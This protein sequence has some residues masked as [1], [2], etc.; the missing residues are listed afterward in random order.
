MTHYQRFAILFAVTEIALRPTI[1]NAMLDGQALLATLVCR[2]ILLGVLSVIIIHLSH[3]C[4]PKR[5]RPAI[6]I[7]CRCS[8]NVLVC[9]WLRWQ[10]LQHLF[11]VALYVGIHRDAF[12]FHLLI[13]GMLLLLSCSYFSAQC[14]PG[15]KFGTCATPLTCV[16]VTGYYGPLCDK[17]L[18]VVVV[19]IMMSFS[20][21]ICWICSCLLRD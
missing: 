10:L 5:L 8:I 17:R 3:S 4:L 6:W 9:P 19:I 13:W 20:F 1:A 7:L 14:T 21:R 16:C 2:A 12:I 18:L 11:V 15:C